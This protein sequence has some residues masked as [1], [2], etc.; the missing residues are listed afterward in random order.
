MSLRTMS[1]GTLVVWSEMDKVDWRT[2][3]NTMERVEE[4]VGRIYRCFLQR[5]E[6][7]IVLQSFNV[8][9]GTQSE[10]RIVRPND[11]LYLMSGTPPP[12]WSG[13]NPMFEPWGTGKKFKF[14]VDGVDHD[15]DVVYSLVKPDALTDQGYT[16]AGSTPHGRAAGA[17]TL[18][19]R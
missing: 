11:P 10:A 6:L 13:G 2:S 16:V 3:G 12:H 7:S 15:V 18:A 8:D 4:V 5:N 14:T 9:D 17:E 19:Y 1:S